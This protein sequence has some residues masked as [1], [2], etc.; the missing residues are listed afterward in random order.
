MDAQFSARTVDF[1]LI[2]T[3]IVTP[4]R[5][6]RAQRTLITAT[7]SSPRLSYL[8]RRIANPTSPLTTADL[9]HLVT[10]G[11]R[12]A[13]PSCSVAAIRIHSVHCCWLLHRD[14]CSPRYSFHRSSACGISF[15]ATLPRERCALS[16]VSLFRGRDNQYKQLFYFMS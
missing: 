11:V 13:P 12:K 15:L 6:A 10:L 16:V 8:H 2:N 3:A 1:V 14:F 4:P 5:S 7:Q 9:C